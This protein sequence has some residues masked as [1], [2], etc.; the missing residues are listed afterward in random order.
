VLIIVAGATVGALISTASGALF[1][2]LTT[3]PLGRGT[4]SVTWTGATGVTP[5]IKSIKGTAGGYSVSGAGRVPNPASILGSASSIPSDL[6]LADIKGTIGGA[7]FTLDIALTLPTSGTSLN[8]R[9]LG[10]VSGTF[11]GQAV[12]AQLTANVS[13]NSYGFKGK[14]GTLHVAGVISQPRRH[15]NTETASASFDITK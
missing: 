4:A 13:S 1:A 11:R 10:K 8:P 15:G 12:V 6:P 2:R 3:I 7:H 9:D 14:I 5:T